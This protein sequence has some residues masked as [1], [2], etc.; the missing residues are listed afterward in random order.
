MVGVFCC[1]NYKHKELENS[2]GRKL[3]VYDE[4]F[5]FQFIIKR[6]IEVISESNGDYYN[7]ELKSTLIKMGRIMDW[8]DVDDILYDGTKEEISN[9][10][11]PAC[12]GK[13]KYTYSKSSNCFTI[14]C[15]ACGYLSKAHGG[16][17][18]NCY[19]FFGKE[20]EI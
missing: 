16:P 7:Y 18:P 5:D 15:K 20:Y 12:G 19:R 6:I 13:I 17:I 9:L 10:K 4:F 14:S 8:Y 1:Y 3:F 11:C 2:F